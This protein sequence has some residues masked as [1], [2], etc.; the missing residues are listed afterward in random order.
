M[1]ITK[2]LVFVFFLIILS[3]LACAAVKDLQPQI[4]INFTEEINVDTL[5]INISCG[6]NA[7][8]NLEEILSANPIFVF[9]PN[10]TLEENVEYTVKAQAKDLGGNL[11]PLIQISFVVELDDLVIDLYQPRFAYT[12]T[13]Q[14]DL[15]INTS[16]HATCRYSHY[17]IDYHSMN[18]FDDTGVIHHTEFNYSLTE[19]LTADKNIFVWCNDTVRNVLVP[20]HFTL[21]YDAT[22]PQI[23][24]WADPNPIIETNLLTNLVVTSNDP[25]V[26]RYSANN[27]TNYSLMQSNF[28]GT[29]NNEFDTVH[30]QQVKIN[31]DT[32]SFDFYIAC[33]NSAGLVSDTKTV[34]VDV[35][36]DTALT[37]SLNSP[38]GYDSDFTV[39][40]NVTPNKQAGISCLFSETSDFASTQGMTHRGKHFDIQKTFSQGGTYT[41]YV[42][43]IVGELNEE[44]TQA[45]TFSIDTSE[46]EMGEVNTTSP[47]END[48]STTYDDTE[49]CAEWSATDNQSGISQY[50]YY[51]YLQNGSKDNLIEDGN[52]NDNDECVDVDLID[53]E[54]YYWVL[55]ARNGVGLWSDNETSDDILV[56]TSKTP[57]SCSN[58][59][60]DG[61]EKAEDCG[62][63]CSAGCPDGI[64]CDIDGD[65][66][67][68]YCGTNNT[69]MSASCSDDVH[70]GAESDLDCGGP[71]SDKCDVGDNCDSD[72]D[73]DSNSCSQTTGF[74]EDVVDSCANH[75]LDIDETDEDCGGNCPRCQVGFDCNSDDDCIYSAECITGIC[76]T[77]PQDG[78]TDGIDDSIDNCPYNSN[79]DQKDLDTDGTG[80]ACDDDSD[81]DGLSDSYEQQYFGCT[82]C[83]DANSDTDG[84]GLT[85]LEE[86]SQ[87]TNPNNP[88]TDGD[89]FSD[90][91]EVDKGTNPLD[92]ND[93]PGNVLPIIL[94]VLA[95][96]AVLGLG[97]FFFVTKL[98]PQLKAKK[99]IGLPKTPFRAPPKVPIKAPIKV[100]VKQPIKPTPKPS[101]TKLK[102]LDIFGRLKKIST[103]QLKKKAKKEWYP[104]V[105]N[106]SKGAKGKIAD[107]LEA[108]ESSEVDIGT[109]LEK[110]KK[111]VS[112]M[113][114]PT[115]KK[116]VK[117]KTVRKSKKKPTKKKPTKKKPTKKKTTK[118]KL[119]KKKPA[120]KKK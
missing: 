67:S 65:C 95:I 91:E 73:C 42:K 103:K 99:P 100:P 60:K 64:S 17:S 22:Y 69:C 28:P 37:I 16:R 38:Q 13:Q 35:A 83:A 118:K 114:E 98:L 11:G 109:R 58:G 75:V 71:C 101:N 8:Y 76:S 55:K 52:T 43:C 85:N 72:D 89:G 59:I 21:F 18:Q 24:A 90:G 14:F 96:I 44:A 102:Y 88:D 113:K 94:L 115:I 108:I 39:L 107:Q 63:K 46:P 66:V 1:K 10:T 119:T 81:N 5:N 49:L 93:K 29:L 70:N 23:S 84:D 7:C 110:L 68:D 6:P 111:K 31:S 92:P 120:A 53:L 20:G 87:R 47:L 116:P 77:R 41:R 45:I 36:L 112:A 78:D 62:G 3:G 79:P 61:D 40:F 12:P 105:K 97:A 2:L 117:K 106:V 80:D 56:D 48:S 74:C 57:I 104:N 51:I 30:Q 15:I 26:C 86:M 19:P 4:T 82:T 50:R 54:K 27:K 32:G 33:N 25:T 34:T 9:K